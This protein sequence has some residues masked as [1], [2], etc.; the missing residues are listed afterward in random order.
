MDHT[1]PATGVIGLGSMGMGAALSSLRA[2]LP[3][4]GLDLRP[5]ALATLT[6]AGGQAAT[7]AADL[8]ARSK[9]VLVY[10]VNAAQARE[11]LFGLMAPSPRPGR[12][13]SS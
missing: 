1:R 13:R 2:G 4:I 3:V 7:D 8:G 5:E 12:V 9:V 11:V 10:V 6:S